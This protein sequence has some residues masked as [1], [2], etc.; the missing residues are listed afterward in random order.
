MSSDILKEIDSICESL[1]EREQL[2]FLKELRGSINSRIK[3]L[4]SS[5]SGKLYNNSF[6]ADITDLV[7]RVFPSLDSYSFYDKY[8]EVRK[9]IVDE[10]GVSFSTKM[11]TCE[12]YERCIEL[13]NEYERG[14]SDE[15]CRSCYLR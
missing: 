5:K 13:L 8:Q 3:G 14:M 11:L 15:R 7:N 9:E 12:E 2:E 4:T 10:L 1:S 6:R